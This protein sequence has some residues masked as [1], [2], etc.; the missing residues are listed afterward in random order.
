M[1]VINLR[2]FT[3]LVVDQDDAHRWMIHNLLKALGV[4]EVLTSSSNED[5]LNLLK[6]LSRKSVTER[7]DTVDFLIGDLKEE[8]LDGISM[9]RWIRMHGDSPNRF[10]PVI[11]MATA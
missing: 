11:L 1:A 4:G 3:A 5:A 9:V 10:L 8:P 6:R 7:I 2:A